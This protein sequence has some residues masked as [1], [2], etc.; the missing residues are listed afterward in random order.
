LARSTV[1]AKAMVMV[2]TSA[3]PQSVKATELLSVRV[4]APALARL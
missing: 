4:S 3:V 1:P 2:K